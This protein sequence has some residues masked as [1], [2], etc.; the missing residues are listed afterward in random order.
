MKRMYLF[1]MLLSLPLYGQVTFKGDVT[2][3]SSTAFYSVQPGFTTNQAT[4]HTTSFII[5]GTAGKVVT[6][7]WGDGSSTSQTLSGVGTDNVV[8][9]DYSTQGSYDIALSGDL[10][11]LTYL[12]NTQAQIS[13][14]IANLSGLTS[15]TYLNLGSTSVSYTTTSLPTWNSINLRVD[16][17]GW[18]AAT[19][20]T[21]IID[22][23]TAGG[24]NGTLNVG[25]NNEPRTSASD[26]AFTNL[27]NVKGWAITPDL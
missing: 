22:L 23:D 10:L 6:F 18:L 15:L 27:K 17:C 16:N 3:K 19:V 24:T 20:S 14:D 25:P 1:L 9:H 2:L 26:A 11:N 12:K 8:T 4:L 7:D 5:R 21:L 13:G